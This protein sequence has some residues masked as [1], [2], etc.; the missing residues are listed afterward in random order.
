M[1]ESGFSIP[2]YNDEALI[3]K[4][5]EYDAGQYPENTG[6]WIRAAQYQRAGL[7]QYLPSVRWKERF[8]EDS[9]A[10]FEKDPSVRLTPEQFLTDEKEVILNIIRT[11]FPEL[12][13]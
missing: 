10:M 13:G 2:L 1:T 5:Y 12:F 4:L 9:G 3:E 7:W 11:D 6:E 8:D